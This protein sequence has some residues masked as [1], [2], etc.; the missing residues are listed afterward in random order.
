M[1]RHSD[2]EHYPLLTLCVPLRRCPWK[3]SYL[4]FS[5][6]LEGKSYNRDTVYIFGKSKK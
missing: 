2:S 5:V 4:R 3:T 1:T 6:V